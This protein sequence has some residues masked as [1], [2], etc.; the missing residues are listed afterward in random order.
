MRALVILIVV[1][2]AAAEDGEELSPDYHRT[3]P[4]TASSEPRRDPPEGPGRDNWSCKVHYDCKHYKGFCLRSEYAFCVEKACK[5][6]PRNTHSTHHPYHHRT[7]WD[8]FWLQAM[9]PTLIDRYANPQ[10]PLPG[11]CFK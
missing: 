5:C 4:V 3:S 6:L 2:A 1:A 8:S 9:N 11:T 7:Q 10:S